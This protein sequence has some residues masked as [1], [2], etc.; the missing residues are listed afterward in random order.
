MNQD[1][2]KMKHLLVLLLEAL[3]LDPETSRS[4]AAM[5]QDRTEAAGL[6][7]DDVHDLLAWIE[8][9]ML[10][11]DEPHW[12]SEPLPEAPSAK[13]FRY[14]GE[15]DARYLTP[16]GMGFL[17]SLLN[18]G[19]IS[20]TQLEALLAYASRVAYR[21]MDSYDLEPILEQVLF[22]PGRPGMTGGASEG[23]GNI[24]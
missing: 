20:G 18:N 16:E 2:D 14:F 13:A 22:M 12:P 10:P 11:S 8:N 19:Q 6:S 3:S 7:D 24:H 17:I 15:S 4:R 1:H 21:P 23:F 5:I 9:H